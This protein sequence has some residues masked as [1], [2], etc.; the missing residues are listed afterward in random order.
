MLYIYIFAINNTIY[1][2][3]RNTLFS[4]YF[5]LLAFSVFLCIISYWYTLTN[6]A[7][8]I[9]SEQY[10]MNTSVSMDLGRWGTNLIRCQLFG[11]IIPFYTLF[12]GLLFL[13]LAAVEMCHIFKLKGILGYIFCGLLLTFPQ[14]SY[15]LFFT[16]QA[17]AIGIGFFPSA[18]AM[19]LYF[20]IGESY[21][22]K[23]SILAF[24]A[25]AFLLMFVTA[26]Y[27]ALIFIPIIIYIIVFFQKT[28]KE[29]FDFKTEFKNTIHFIVLL[30]TSVILYYISIKI[31]CPSNSEGGFM[32]SYTSA[33][34]NNRFIDFYNLWVDILRGNIFY[35]NKTF[36][37]VSLLSC[38]LLIKYAF[39]KTNFVYKLIAIF[40]L[41]FIPF[42]I[43]IFITTGSP[44]RLY[45]ASGIVFAFLIVQFI[46]TIKKFEN[47]IIFLCLLICLTNIYFITMLFQSNYKI[48]DHDKKVGEKI[49]SVIQNKYPEFNSNIGYVYFYGKLSDSEYDG[50]RIPKSDVFT[51]S[52]FQWDEGSNNRILNF[53]KFNSIANY[54]E[55]TNKE[56]FLKIKD[57]INS[58]ST[59]PRKES[60]KLFGDV[61]VIKLG[62][63]KGAKLAVE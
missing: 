46:S 59:W 33:E 14:M 18:L 51:S 12:L 50:F 47:V 26:I 25:S 1:V 8:T 24:F 35:G 4:E 19:K 5:K 53:M 21:F 45:V 2:L 11:S 44:P 10:F 31:I 56:D 22:T 63:V 37:L 17:D 58:M 40:L 36:V 29:H 6:F 48:F 49:N 13:S 15:Q 9:D 23:K 28:L 43:S 62:N 3:M 60:V 7:L 42:F 55:I 52:F 39:G 16:M 41:L 30:L 38:V 34:N 20:E 54:K 27:Q 32:A 61:I 57:S